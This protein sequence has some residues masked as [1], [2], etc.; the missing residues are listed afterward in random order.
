MYVK[1]YNTV[2]YPILPSCF[3]ICSCCWMSSQS[4]FSDP[5]YIAWLRDTLALLYLKEGIEDITNAV[6]KKFHHDLKLMLGGS[7]C[8]SCSPR[9]MIKDTHGWRWYMKCWVC[10]AW[11]K[12]IVSNH[13]S[14]PLP[15]IHR[16]NTNPQLWP[17]DPWEVLKCYMGYGCQG[18]H[19]AKDADTQNL[20]TLFK[21]C[22]QFDTGGQITRMDLI[23]EVSCM[24]DTW[25]SYM[26][27]IL[28]QYLQYSLTCTRTHHS[29]P[30]DNPFG[31]K[32][33]PFPFS[34]AL[35]L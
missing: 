19:S 31:K 3:T 10:D 26:G 7:A 8:T 9:D 28:I 25:T 1:N 16:D 33:T 30:H 2:L 14:Q 12:Q 35:W 29:L 4:R 5:A 27:F 18:I 24:P 22:P 17:T 6:A 21:N 13:G 15:N 20:L 34:P 32:S 11:L 23:D